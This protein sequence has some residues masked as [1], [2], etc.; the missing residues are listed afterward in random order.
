MDRYYTILGISKSASPEEIKKAF[1]TQA[2]KWHPDR[3]PDQ[4]EL[5]D[6]KFKEINEAYEVLSNPEKRKIYD[7]YGE[8]GL[9]GNGSGF[10]GEFPG[11]FQ[12]FAF[13]PSMLFG[14]FGGNP[15]GKQSAIHPIPC[16]LEQL[17]NGATIHPQ[18]N[19]KTYDIEIKP[20][21]RG[22]I[23]IRY[24]DEIDTPHGKIDLIF[25]I[26]EQPHP[27]YRRN[28][29]DLI[30]TVGIKLRQALIGCVIT[31][32]TLD[33]R[34]IRHPIRNIITPSTV[35]RIPNEGMPNPNDPSK[36]GNLIL[37]FEIEFPTQLTQKE[38]DQL[39]KIL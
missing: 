29:Q 32:P 1:R 23:K 14:M 3:N 37:I 38:K 22:G 18:I 20:G 11:G 36:K 8:D 13:D 16:T 6:Q 21:F 28:N 35:E 26:E 31:I 5:A 17:Y 27:L 7:Q 33:G 24:P 10:P 34:A 39:K 9:K 12:Q 4:K 30:Y 25:V 19:G 2:L 15:F